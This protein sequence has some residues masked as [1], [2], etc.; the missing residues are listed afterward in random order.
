M[1]AKPTGHGL[2]LPNAHEFGPH[3]RRFLA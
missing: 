1:N 3:R 2:S